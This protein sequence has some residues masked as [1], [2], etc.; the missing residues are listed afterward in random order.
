MINAIKKNNRIEF[1]CRYSDREILKNG[2]AKWDGKFKVWYLPL[3]LSNYYNIL[4]IDNLKIAEELKA[5]F[6]EKINNI[7]N[8]ETKTKLY[9]HQEKLVNLALQKE[10]VFFLC[11]VGTGK[12]LASIT[13]VD[14]LK[15][16]GKVNKCLVVSPACI[17]PN[18]AN[19]IKK[20]SYFDYVT[21][22]GTINQR[23]EKLQQNVLYYIINYEV[24]EKLEKELCLINFDALICDEIHMIKNRTTQR[25]KALY[26]I[27]NGK[28]VENKT[29][30]NADNK[31]YTKKIYKIISNK[32]KYRIGLSGTIIANKWEDIFMPYKIISPEI[33]GESFTSFKD[34][35]LV[36]GGFNA[37]WGGTQLLGYKNHDNFKKLIAI[38]SLSYDLDDVVD[39]PAEIEVIKQF[40]LN[41]KNLKIYKQLEKNFLIEFEAEQKTTTNALENL[42]RLSQVCSGFLPEIKGGEAVKNRVQ[43]LGDEKIEVLKELLDEIGNKKTIIWCKFKYSIDKIVRLLKKN[44]ISFCLYDGRTTDKDLY[45]KFE[46]NNTQIFLAQL[47]T[48]VGYSLPSAQYAIFYEIDYS[49]IHHIQAKG[50]NRRLIGSS[51]NS[52]VYF[53]LIANKTIETKILK[54][55][56]DKDFTAQD[57][58]T[59]VKQ[60]G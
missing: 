57:A 43:D 23:K 42:L 15:K 56:K 55:L 32:I 9:L 38:N 34:N 28:V 31:E 20:Y 48:G 39:L 59:L 14:T 46:N 44:N 4:A 50:R 19:E 3:N 58:L 37:G 21:L 18:F 22:T 49:R 51:K 10:R 30:K 53:Y 7:N 25:S 29:F 26:N 17:I 47:A 6:E 2:G 24:L 5:S 27:S 11:G 52:C 41:N 8:I 16:Q 12:S 54:V 36:Y 13:V 35:F 45:L 1:L 60:G 40:E 33:F